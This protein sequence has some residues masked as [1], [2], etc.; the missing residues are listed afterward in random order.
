MGIGFFTTRKILEA[1]GV[2]DLGISNAVGSAVTMF[3]FI[4]AGLT[5]S[6]QRFLNIGLGKKDVKLTNQYFSQGLMLQISLAL[7]L[8]AI[9]YP[10]G[11]WLVQYKMI[12]PIERLSAAMWIFRF[13]VVS[14][15]IRFIRISFESSVIARE[16][17]SFYAYLSMLEGFGKL[18]ICYLIIYN[19]IFDNLIYYGVCLLALNC[20]VTLFNVVYCEIKFP[21]TRFRFYTDKDV[22]KLLTCFIGLNSVGAAS[23]ALAKYGVDVLINMFFGP[24]VN[25]AKGL[26]SQLDRLVSQ[27]GTNVDLA[28]RPQITK[29]AAQNESEKMVALAMKGARYI[30]FIMLLVAMPFLF[31]TKTLLVIWL[32]NVP[33]YTD[34]FVKV[35]VF[36]VLFSTIG[37]PF[38]DMCI[39]IGKIKNIE[40]CGR[41]LFTLSILPIGYVILHFFDSPVILLCIESFLALL[42]TLFVAWECNRH[43]HFG[44]LLYVKKFLMPVFLMMLPLGVIGKTVSYIPS[45]ANIYVTFGIKSCL[46]WFASF[47]VIFLFGVEKNDRLFIIT[48]IKEKLCK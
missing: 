47:A 25:A 39:A 33:E 14:L 29:M 1:L 4:S 19:N 45:I 21:E 48:R 22:F 36:N 24:A 37:S 28:I 27:F 42:Y 7:L 3:D 38:S 11:F 32:K 18:V 31:E 10:I 43:L 46:L 8:A 12:I 35:I 44:M 16:Q 34:V 40:V 23:Y 15:I 26:A 9:V 2:V 5:N 41:L 6:S 20:G 17:M 13:S 30:F